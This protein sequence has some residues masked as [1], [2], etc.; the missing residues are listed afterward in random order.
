LLVDEKKSL[1]DKIQKINLSL[2]ISKEENVKKNKEQQI[3]L[4]K[5]KNLQKYIKQQNDNINST[6]NELNDKIITDKI[7][8]IDNIIIYKA[9]I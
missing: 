5:I 9:K 7:I 8:N 4:E 2:D 6:K 3:F 1:S